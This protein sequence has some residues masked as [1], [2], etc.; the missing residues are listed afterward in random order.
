VTATGLPDVE[1]TPLD[2]CRLPDELELDDDEVDDVDDEVAAVFA[3][4]AVDVDA[5]GMVAA[6]T[7]AKTP[8]PASEPAAAPTVRRCSNRSAASRERTRAWVALVVGMGLSLPDGAK[9]YLRAG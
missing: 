1:L 4:C 2:G 3:A 7:A 6:L 5:P 8:T 9:S